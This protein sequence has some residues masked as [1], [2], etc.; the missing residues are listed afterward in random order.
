M[1]RILSFALSLFLLAPMMF[2]CN[3]ENSSYSDLM[4]GITNID[5]TDDDGNG[6]ASKT[7]ADIHLSVEVKD[8]VMEFRT[9]SDSKA[10]MDKHVECAVAV[11]V[12]NKNLSFGSMYMDDAGMIWFRYSYIFFDACPSIGVIATIIKMAVETMD[13]YDD[14][15]IRGIR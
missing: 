10:P 7:G 1:K 3:N 4:S 6:S 5:S 9:R 14:I 8:G 11:N 15:I 13:R 12:V 2:S